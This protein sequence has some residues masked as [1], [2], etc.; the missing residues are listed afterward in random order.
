MGGDCARKKVYLSVEDGCNRNL[1]HLSI[2]DGF[3]KNRVVCQWIFFNSAQLSSEDGFLKNRLT[4]QLEV[5][6]F[7]ILCP[8]Q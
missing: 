2:K 7:E 1:M 5:V 8:C 4:Y 3:L 6:L